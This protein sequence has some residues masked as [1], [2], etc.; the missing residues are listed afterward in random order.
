MVVAATLA[1]QWRHVGTHHADAVFLRSVRADAPPGE[2]VYA[3]LDV[4]EI[5]GFHTLYYLGDRAV[6]LHNLTFLRDDRIRE[7]EVLVVTRMG[8]RAALAALGEPLVVSQSE[9][10]GRADRSEDRMTLFRLRFREDLERYA[11]R[12]VRV[13]PLQALYRKEGPFLGPSR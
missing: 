11:A 13:S 5:R 2:A 10:T 8:K 6:P 7:D 1:L 12:D 9:R 4:G 3:D